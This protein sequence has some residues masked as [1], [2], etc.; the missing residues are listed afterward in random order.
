M[1]KDKRVAVPWNFVK[2]TRF[3]TQKNGIE[4]RSYIASYPSRWMEEEEIR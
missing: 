3:A 4:S 2:N 1:K